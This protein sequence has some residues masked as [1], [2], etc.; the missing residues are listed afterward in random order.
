MQYQDAL[1]I[2]LEISADF[3]GSGFD[4]VVGN[5]DGQI[6]TCGALGWTWRFGDHQQMVLQ[7]ERANPGATQKYM[8]TEGKEYLDLC[9]ELVARTIPEVTRWTRSG[10]GSM[11]NEPYLSELKA[12]WGSPEMIDIQVSF[13]HRIGEKAIRYDR[14]WVMSSQQDFVM[15]VQEFCFFFDLVVNN[16]SLLGLSYSDV[17]QR[18]GGSGVI[19]G[20]ISHWCSVQ[21]NRDSRRN[22]DYWGRLSPIDNE[23]NLLVLGWL[24]ALKAKREWA[25]SVMNRRGILALGSGYCEGEKKD[26]YGR[27]PTFR[28][29]KIEL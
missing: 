23:R 26:L 4:N 18:I 7:C 9:G 28:D 17:R 20:E 27:F 15:T 14:D 6:L 12:F 19:L 16:G 3:E 1:K 29:E 8:P 11:V 10:H 24:R 13:A 25:P 5:F 21:S 2:A 22:A